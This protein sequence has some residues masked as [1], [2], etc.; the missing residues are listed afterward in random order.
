MSMT[1]QEDI[2]AWKHCLLCKTGCVPC[3]GNRCKCW[4][5]QAQV[6]A[7]NELLQPKIEE[8]YSKQTLDIK[9]ATDP[10]M[11]EAQKQLDLERRGWPKVV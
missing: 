6:K 9:Y 10:Y 8:F 11:A 2:K 1:L 5:N 7:S 4:M 3:N